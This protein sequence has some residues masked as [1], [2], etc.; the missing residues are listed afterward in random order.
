VD[1]PGPFATVYLDVSHDTDDAERAIALRWAQARDELTAQGADAAT[2]D[3]LADAVT[4]APP[5]VGRAG[6]VLVAR[7]AGHPL[8]D[9]VAALLRYPLPAGV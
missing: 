3:A 5:A 7:L 1:L 6:R 2:L 8:D 9:G 4:D